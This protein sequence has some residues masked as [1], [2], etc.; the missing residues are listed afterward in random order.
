MVVHHDGTNTEEFLMQHAFKERRH[1]DLDGG[2]NYCRQGSS[3][4]GPRL[5]SLTG[6]GTLM[7]KAIAVRNP[8]V[9]CY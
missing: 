6:T 7:H 1:R 8:W 5:D 4:T 2:C 9:L 3:S